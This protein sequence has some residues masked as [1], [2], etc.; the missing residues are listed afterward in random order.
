MDLIP[1]SLPENRICVSEWP[2]LQSDRAATKGSGP[3]RLLARPDQSEAGGDLIKCAAAYFMRGS[4]HLQICLGLIYPSSR[5]DVLELSPQPVKDR[6]I[7]AEIEPGAKHVR[8]DD[9]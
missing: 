2:I 9:R 3:D 5:S 4:A 1:K 7:W 6:Q 8:R